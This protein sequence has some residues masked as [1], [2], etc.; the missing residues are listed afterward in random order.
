MSDSGKTD[1]YVGYK[2]TAPA[3]LARFVRRWV[4]AGLAFAAAV[5]ITLVLSQGRFALAFFEFGNARSF[6]GFVSEHPY[7]TLLVPRPEA[8]DTAI[9][10]SRYLLSVPGKFGAADVMQGRDGHYVQL[11]GTLVYRDDQTMIE[12]VPKSVQTLADADS[13]RS[14][15]ARTS[16]GRFTL[17]G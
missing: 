2:E 8:E 17:K 16:I 15:L 1:F 5:A 12:V 7:P 14:N 10:F 6:E 9:P 13:D 11:S 4:L 3:S